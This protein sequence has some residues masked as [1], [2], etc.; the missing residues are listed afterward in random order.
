MEKLSER[1]A[2]ETFVFAS[3]QDE[4]MPEI[5]HNFG[6]HTYQPTAGAR[7]HQK[8]FPK[9]ACDEKIVLFNQMC[10]AFAQ[11]LQKRCREDVG[12]YEPLSFGCTTKHPPQ[13]T[14]R[15]ARKDNLD[16]LLTNIQSGAQSMSQIRMSRRREHLRFIEYQQESPFGAVEATQQL[17]ERGAGDFWIIANFGFEGTFRDSRDLCGG[18]H[19]FQRSP[20]F[21]DQR[22]KPT[23]RTR[24]AGTFAPAPDAQSAKDL[25]C[26]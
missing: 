18:F 14:L 20:E 11:R 12:A 5:V 22:S 25:V 24:S 19:L 17:R 21:L 16:R 7:T 3:M 8:E 15:A 4:L 1:P 6:G 9:S 10:M 23:R 26:S 13:R 2:A